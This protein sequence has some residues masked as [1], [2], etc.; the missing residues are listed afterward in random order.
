MTIRSKAARVVFDKVSKVPRIINISQIDIKGKDTGQQRP[1]Q[2][3]ASGATI[4][5]ECLATTF[6]LSDA[7][8]PAD[9]K[10]PAGRATPAAR[11]P[12]AKRS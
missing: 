11:Q 7:P 10:K 3:S 9:P 12:A 8:P 2:A 6:V 1:T 4:A 5:A